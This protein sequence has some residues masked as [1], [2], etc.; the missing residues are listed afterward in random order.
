[1][2]SHGY[3]ALE[4]TADVALLFWADEPRGIFQAAQ[5]AVMEE[6]TEGHKLKELSQRSLSVEAL[7]L[8]DLLVRWINELLLLAIC[9]GFLCARAEL[10]LSERSLE[11]QLFG[12]E[13]G[14]EL[15]HNELKS[16]T[17]HDLS[18]EPSER[19]FEARV[20]IDV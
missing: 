20:I 11:A 9:D 14:Y 12:Q 7:D 3:R 5:E 6:L 15:I 10:L 13:E 19:G 2:M 8:E 16:A 18:F 17:Y 1:M 4:H